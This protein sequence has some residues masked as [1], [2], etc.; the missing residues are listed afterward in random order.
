MDKKYS[1]IENKYGNKYLLDYKSNP[2]LV[3]NLGNYFHQ[4]PHNLKVIK[5]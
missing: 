1:Y 3:N 5:I 2:I 4:I